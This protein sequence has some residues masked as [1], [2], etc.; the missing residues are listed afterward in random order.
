MARLRRQS[1]TP[2]PTDEEL[3]ERCL[4]HEKQ[5]WDAFV[6]RYLRLIYSVVYDTLRR[7][8][9]PCSPERVDGLFGDVFLALYDHNY[10]KL[11][12]WNRRCSLASWVRL[13]AASTV[14]DKLRKKR[15]APM[16]DED[17]SDALAR[18]PTDAED[19]VDLLSR[20]DR[21]RAVR[22]AMAQLGEADRDLLTRLF[23]QEQ[24]PG[25]V[26]AALKIKPGALYTRK[27]RALARLKAIL[28]EQAGGDL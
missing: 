24:G 21:I 22:A 5:A 2:L 16:A 15:P 18:L 3:L 28:E 6:D 23:A 20:V 12:Q 13:V 8:G 1:L 10:R 11:R 7:H 25:E 17:L 26:A 19:A 4:N 14:V 9:E 27:N